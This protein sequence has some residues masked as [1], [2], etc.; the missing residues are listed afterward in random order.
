MHMQRR[1]DHVIYS[2]MESKSTK[3]VD[4]DEIAKNIQA[5]RLQSSPRTS[6][7]SKKGRSKAAATTPSN[8]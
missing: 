7:R 4:D 2:A 8:E 3:A 1:I 5:L 6:P